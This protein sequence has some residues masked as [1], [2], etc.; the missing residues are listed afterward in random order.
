M[1]AAASVAIM[2][3][4]TP[5]RALDP[6][7]Y[8]LVRIAAGMMVI[9]CYFCVAKWIAARYGHRHVIEF[10]VVSG[11][12]YLG[13]QNY[14][15]GIAKMLLNRF[16]YDGVLDDHI[17]MKYAIAI[18]VMIAIYPFAWA[19]DHYAPWLIGKKKKQS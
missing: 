13:L 9:P 16:A 12:V 1:L 11:T 17:W 3:E 8:S 10:V 14:F 6:Q 19:I 15:I 4:A 18:M 7:L 2:V 5:L